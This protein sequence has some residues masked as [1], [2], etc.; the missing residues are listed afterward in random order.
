[1]VEDAPPV[2]A[3]AADAPA[4]EELGIALQSIGRINNLA[5]ANFEVGTGSHVVPAGN[6]VPGTDWRLEAVHSR[7]ALL[8][9]GDETL[10]LTVGDAR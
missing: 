5:C 7:G 6:R 4:G 9:D 3:A 10:T 1:M 2:P 8:R